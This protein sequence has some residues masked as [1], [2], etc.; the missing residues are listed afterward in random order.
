MTT[1]FYENPQERETILSEIIKLSQQVKKNAPR[2][3]QPIPDYLIP[4]L[5]LESRKMNEKPQ[6][7]NPHK[8][9][10]LI[11]KAAHDEDYDKKLKNRVENNDLTM[12]D[13]KKKRKI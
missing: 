12:D 11:K 5:I 13:V 3:D 7:T 8:K 6:P 4:K 1:Y 10:I 2:C 9:K